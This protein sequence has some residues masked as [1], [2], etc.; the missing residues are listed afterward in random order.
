MVQMISSPGQFT[1][2]TKGAK[3]LKEEEDEKQELLF[4]ATC[5]VFFV[6]GSGWCI[7]STG[8]FFQSSVFKIHYK[9][10]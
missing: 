4:S 7:Y 8:V 5:F 9:I 6:Y 3:K 1:G 10:R 2:M